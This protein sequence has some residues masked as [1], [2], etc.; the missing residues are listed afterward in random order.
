VLVDE[1]EIVL[2]VLKTPFLLSESIGISLPVL[3]HPHLENKLNLLVA[4]VVTTG[5]GG[6]VH[7]RGRRRKNEYNQ[8]KED[9][10]ANRSN[11][12]HFVYSS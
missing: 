6:K 12:A 10:H 11:K 7:G 8:K 9:C 5:C 3:G 2:E 4:P 1:T